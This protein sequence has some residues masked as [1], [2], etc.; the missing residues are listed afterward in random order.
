LILA[1]LLGA[2]CVPRRE[3]D[4][5][6]AASEG[7]GTEAPADVSRA[8]AE[9][10]VLDAPQACALLP[11]AGLDPVLVRSVVLRARH[12]EV[13]GGTLVVTD[14]NVQLVGRGGEPVEAALGTR[15]RPG[16]VLAVEREDVLVTPP[17]HAWRITG[18]DRFTIYG[19]SSLWAAPPSSER[20][21]SLSR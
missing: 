12:A 15:L 1:L 6:L 8:L 18:R 14:L 5:P 2:A 3:I 21:P 16:L 10:I 17:A 13:C 9:G 20:S 11:T 19:V 4:A 7:C